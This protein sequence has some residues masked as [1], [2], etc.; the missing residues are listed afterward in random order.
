MNPIECPIRLDLTKLAG[1]CLSGLLSLLSRRSEKLWAKLPLYSKHRW[2]C[3]S[4]LSAE[5]SVNQQEPD[6]K[7]AEYELKFHHSD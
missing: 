2:V 5:L 7:S 6:G 1:S 4:S 3:I